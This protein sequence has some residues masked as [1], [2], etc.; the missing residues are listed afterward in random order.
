MKKQLLL[1]IPVFLCIFISNASAACIKTA[2]NYAAEV[3]LNKPGIDSSLSKL[4]SAKNVIISNNQYILKSACSPSLAAILENVNDLTSGN[5]SGLSVRLQIPVKAEGKTYPY[6][7]FVSTGISGTLN[8]TEDSY[9]GWKIS[10]A[11]GSLSLQCEFDKG[12]TSILV[13]L[14]SLDKYELTIETREDLKACGTC[15]GRCVVG[16]GESRCINKQLMSDMEDM[17]KHAGLVNSFDEVLVS[18]RLISA[19]SITVTDLVPETSETVDW[20]SAMSKELAFLRSEGIISITDS[21]ISAIS[22][23]ASEGAAGQNSRIVY[24]ED[25]SGNA[26]WLYYSQ[27]KFPV[28]TQLTNCREYPLSEI[29]AGDVYFPS[30]SPIS[31]VYY[32]VPLVI[33]GSLLLLFVILAIIARAVERKKK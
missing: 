13:N 12:D 27:T 7:E 2:D 26:G 8:V 17:L 14:V 11:E 29:P 23:L 21:D 19:A 1:L 24:G 16:S 22:K 4:D 30:P 15:D 31:N 5:S 9:N 3:V 18:Y 10:C 20:N 33:A 28:T 32:L 25:N 6:L